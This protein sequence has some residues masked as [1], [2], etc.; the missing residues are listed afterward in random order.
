MIYLYTGTPGSGKSYH[1]AQAIDKALRRG[2]PV[3]SNFEVNL[4]PKKHKGKFVYIPTKD[5]RI[6]FMMEFARLNFSERKGESQGLII[7]D[8]AQVPFNRRKP[9]FKNI[10]QWVDF[11]SIHRH[12][13]YDIVLITQKHKSLDDQILGLVETEYKHRKL[14]NFGW[15]GYLMMFLFH[16]SFVAVE[17]WFPIQ[18]KVGQTFF[19]CSK[20]IREFYNTFKKFD[21][22]EDVAAA[23]EAL[24]KK[25]AEFNAKKAGGTS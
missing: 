18:E 6:D 7:I 16:K 2:M 17:Y 21:D 15:K 12:Y 3:I 24:N 1:A 13:F 20:R 14:K 8:E 25:I 19:N 9:L 23:K 4:N 11:M 22:N 5:L 10:I